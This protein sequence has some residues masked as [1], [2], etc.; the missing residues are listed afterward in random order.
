MSPRALLAPLALGLFAA[1][2]AAP[3]S[4]P[5][6]LPRAA[7]SASLEEPVVSAPSAPAADPALDARIAAVLKTLAE[8]TA[9]FDIAATAAERQVARAGNAPA[10]SEAWLDAQV[11]L[12]ELDA[13][14]SATV[15]IGSDLEDLA[16]ERALALS[17]DYASLTAALEQVRAAAQ[18]QAARIAA[19]QARLAPA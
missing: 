5:S 2:C 12:A 13:G 6:L 7:E 4:Y 3:G 8:R 9:A 11:A 10:G 15:E 1:G 19:L 18:S 17:P 16:S 14:R